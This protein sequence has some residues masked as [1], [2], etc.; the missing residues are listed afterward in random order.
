MTPSR[1][2]ARLLS[3]SDFPIRICE[4]E[5][6]EGEIRYGTLSHCW[7]QHPEN[8]IQLKDGTLKTFLD[9]IPLESMPKT[10]MDAV[11]FASSLGLSYL[12]IDSLCIIQDSDDDWKREA[13]FMGEIYGNSY[14]NIAASGAL[15]ASEGCLFEAHPAKFQRTQITPAGS[16]RT[17]S[18]D[19]FPDEL[20]EQLFKHSPLVLRAWCF[21]ERLLATRTLHFGKSQLFWECRHNRPSKMLMPGHM[22]VQQREQAGQEH[23]SGLT[24]L[25][26]CLFNICMDW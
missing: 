22:S 4:S 6:L 15:D 16:D 8:L 11:L 12:W 20:Y 24:A 2:P 5:K 9:A 21:Q 7:G 18:Y 25:K 13:S 14:I 10:F 3:I 26:Y 19:C 1:L 17:Q 23:L